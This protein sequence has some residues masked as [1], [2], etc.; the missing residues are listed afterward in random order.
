VFMISQGKAVQSDD[1]DD[2]VAPKKATSKPNLVRRLC[3]FCCCALTNTGAQEAS[4][5][6]TAP[7]KMAQS[8]VKIASVA[9]KVGCVCVLMF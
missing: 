5:K 2:H 4:K 7:S 1:E 6:V 8:E 9:G 3:W